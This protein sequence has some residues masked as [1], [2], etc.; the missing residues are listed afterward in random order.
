MKF[1]IVNHHF[2]NKITFHGEFTMAELEAIRL[3]HLDRLVVGS[4]AKSCADI[5]QSLEILFR[6]WAEQNPGADAM[7]E[8]N[9][10]R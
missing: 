5:L 7:Y 2:D 6:R 4:P 3:D 8:A 1:E 10:E 9:H